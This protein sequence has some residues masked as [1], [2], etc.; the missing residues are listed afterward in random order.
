M[1]VIVRKTFLVNKTK[2][3]DTHNKESIIYFTVPKNK[4]FNDVM[5][6][7]SSNSEIIEIEEA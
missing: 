7:L 3:G 5:E 4:L 1:G 6:A 2:T